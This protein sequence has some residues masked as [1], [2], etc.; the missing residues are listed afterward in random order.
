MTHNPY[1]INLHREGSFRKPFYHGILIDF[2]K[3]QIF[4]YEKKNPKFEM[5]DG[6][7][8]IG[9]EKLTKR[10]RFIT[11]KRSLTEDEMSN[12]A[13]FLKNDNRVKKGIEN[14]KIKVYDF[15]ILSIAIYNLKTH[16]FIEIS[17]F[18][19]R[20]L[21]PA[22]EEIRKL[23]DMIYKIG[24]ECNPEGGPTAFTTTCVAGKS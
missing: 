8:P 20:V 10:R 24:E 11:F 14:K 16:K 22:T 13:R 5:L 7:N 6:S 9:F 4:C 19:D 23:Q 17:A 1:L 18:G 15:G 12:F 21:E 3:E 2:Q